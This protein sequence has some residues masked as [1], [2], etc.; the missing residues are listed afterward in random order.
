MFWV[1]N[2]WIMRILEHLHSALDSDA[3]AFTLAVI[4]ACVTRHKEERSDGSGWRVDED[5]MWH[6]KLGR[7]TL[8]GRPNGMLVAIYDDKELVRSFEAAEPESR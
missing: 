3:A 1:Y 8:T 6:S 5:G 4:H 2:K 7:T